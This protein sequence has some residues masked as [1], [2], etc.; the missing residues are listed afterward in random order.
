MRLNLPAVLAFVCLVS[1]TVVPVPAQ[2]QR[3]M[4]K[5]DMKKRRMVACTGHYTNQALRTLKRMQ[6]RP[7][8]GSCCGIS[9]RSGY[10]R[11]LGG[12]G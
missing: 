2:A 12:I 10:R 11:L 4:R 1:G 9:R 7:S 6:S 5:G 8:N 3:R